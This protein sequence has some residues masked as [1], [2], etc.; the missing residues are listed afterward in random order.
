MSDEEAARNL[1]TS[2]AVDHEMTSMYKC[3]TNPMQAKWINSSN[4]YIFIYNSEKQAC[5][6]LAIASTRCCNSESLRAMDSQRLQAKGWPPNGK[7]PDAKV[8]ESRHRHHGNRIHDTHGW[9]VHIVIWCYMHGSGWFQSLPGILQL[10]KR[11]TTWA[12]SSLWPPETR[13]AGTSL[14]TFEACPKG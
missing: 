5:K 8:A 7:K 2:T 11:F 3:G 4:K 1:W 12:S 6:A 14:E 9:L 10:K 13:R